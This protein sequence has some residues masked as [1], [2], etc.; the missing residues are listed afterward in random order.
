MAVA[1][2]SQRACSIEAGEVAILQCGFNIP[3]WIWT[4]ADDDKGGD[5]DWATAAGGWTGFVF[6]SARNLARQE[7]L[8]KHDRKL[9]FYGDRASLDLES[10]NKIAKIAKNYVIEEQQQLI[11]LSTAEP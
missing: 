5:D 10:T 6:R 8:K 1:L 11:D 2:E 9:D 3:D 7:S 4:F